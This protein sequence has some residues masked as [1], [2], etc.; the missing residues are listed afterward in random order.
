MRFWASVILIL[1]S[2]GC[3]ATTDIAFDPSIS[4]QAPP[5]VARISPTNG[6]AGDTI[7]VFGFGFSNA[8]AANVVTVGDAA[9]EA[10]TYSLVDPAVGA[11]IEKITFTVPTGAIIGSG[12]LFVTVFDETSNN[13]VA[14]TVDP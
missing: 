13:N 2:I 12:T 8:A 10:A 9:T 7:T 4:T 11:E 14:F 5:F 1:G 6:Q 3:G